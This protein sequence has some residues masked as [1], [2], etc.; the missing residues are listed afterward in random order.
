[1]KDDIF[2]SFDKIK[3]RALEKEAEKEGIARVH[4]TLMKEYGGGINLWQFMGLEVDVPIKMETKWWK[5]KFR[6]EGKA[7]IK[8]KSLPLPTLWNLLKMINKDNKKTK[9]ELDNLKS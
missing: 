4:H 2:L 5:F 3:Q 8:I 9:E 6:H 1:M 7:K